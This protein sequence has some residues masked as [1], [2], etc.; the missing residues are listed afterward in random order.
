MAACLNAN[1]SKFMLF[2]SPNKI[3]Y[4]PSIEINSTTVDCVDNFNFLG[5]LLDKHLNWS[6]KQVE[7]QTKYLEQLVYWQN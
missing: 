5:I 7:L 2:N 3:I 1:K 4:I 6:V